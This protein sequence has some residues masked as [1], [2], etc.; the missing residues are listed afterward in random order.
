M[1]SVP[2]ET[3]S[4]GTPYA[5]I[6]RTA[7]WLLYRVQ[8]A[9]L[10]A[11]ILYKVLT[12]LIFIPLMQRIWSLG[13][14]LS[15]TKY[16]TT[17]NLSRLFLSP[18]VLIAA[19]LIASATAWWTLYEFSLIICGLDAAQHGEPCR[20]RVLLLRA[21]KSIRHA[22]LPRNWGVLFYA[23]LLIPFTNVVVNSNYISQLAIPEYIDEVIKDNA[24]THG[25]YLL[26]FFGLCVLNIAWCLSMHFF[27]L[28][29]ECYHDAHHE[30]LAWIRKRPL[31]IVGSLIRW[32][33]RSSIGLLL[34]MIVPGLLYVIT[35]VGAGL[36]SDTLMHTLLHS[37]DGILKPF[38]SFLLDC[39]GTLM[40][41]AFLSASYYAHRGLA[42]PLPKKGWKKDPSYRRRGRLALLFSCFAVFAAWIL[43]SLLLAVMPDINEA[44]AAY[45]IPSTT[46]TSHRG[47]S[48]VAPE[49]TLPAFEAAIEVGADCAELD[50]Q[51]TKDG[52]VVVTHDTNLKRC[53]GMDANVYDLN[54]EEIRALDAG[55][56]M[57][58][59]FAGTRIPTLQ[60]V[61][62]TC[63]GRIRLNIEIK[64][65]DRTPSL[66]AETARLIEENGWINDCVV[67]SLNYESLVKIKQRN[68]LI[69]CGYIMAVGLGSYYDLPAADFFSVESTFVSA[70]MV[71]QLHLRGKKVSVWTIDREE[72]ANRMKELGVDDII[73]GNPPMVQA[74]LAKRSE[75]ESFWETLRDA[76]SEFVPQRED[77]FVNIQKW[78]EAA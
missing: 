56:Y 76:F 39:L 67:T 53:T 15:P 29:G 33:V 8:S 38:I 52:V 62:D 37:F 6:K 41:E 12:V 1:Q 64:A 74:V 20:L 36:Y 35:I 42:L 9:L 48:A 77:P 27:V 21:A 45:L 70:G 43:L 49:N 69:R 44:L 26:V 46:V 4:S 32:S 73:T 61:L 22:L 18:S 19:L 78:L 72:D 34:L 28:E 47:Y 51:M 24:V 40:M 13:L 63:K 17:D 60:E 25:I 5:V 71:G 7:R 75:S 66:E 54:Y 58:E 14:W 30:S 57:G 16:F 2:S 10:F 3:P 68:I 59:E 11:L 65:S 31:R 55:A 23:A 50:V